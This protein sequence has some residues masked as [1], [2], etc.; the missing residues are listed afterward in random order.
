MALPEPAER[1]GVRQKNGKKATENLQCRRFPFCGRRRGNMGGAVAVALLWFCCG[2]KIH[3]NGIISEANK[4]IRTQAHSRK[5][6]KS[7]TRRAAKEN[8]ADYEIP[9]DYYTLDT[10]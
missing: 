7:E 1:K 10:F 3:H 2:N 9:S 4:A 8:S 5:Q 6:I